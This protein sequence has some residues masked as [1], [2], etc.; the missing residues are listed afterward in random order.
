[1]Q[2]D[3]ERHKRMLA[4]HCRVI[5]HEEVCEEIKVISYPRGTCGLFPDSVTSP[6]ATDGNYHVSQ[7]LHALFCPEL[8][9][10]MDRN[11]LD[12]KV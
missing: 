6:S 9:N 3:V 12:Y 4:K 8:S 2:H 11:Q 10:I 1:M 5:C 7:L